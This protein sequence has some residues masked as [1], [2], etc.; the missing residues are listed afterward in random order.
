LPGSKLK[1]VPVVVRSIRLVTRNSSKRVCQQRR[2]SGYSS[3]AANGETGH[4]SGGVRFPPHDPYFN[5][6]LLFGSY[7]DED[8]YHKLSA[9]SVDTD[10][11]CICNGS[12]QE[13]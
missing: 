13:I 4:C 10:E 5:R 8:G 3:S 9:V 7:R 2:I 1:A 11:R 12:S 6:N